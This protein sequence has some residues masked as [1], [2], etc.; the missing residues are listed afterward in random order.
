MLFQKGRI[1]KPLRRT[2]AMLVRLVIKMA[3]PRR[4]ERPTLGLGDRCSIH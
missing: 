3:A 1:A 2:A 4:I